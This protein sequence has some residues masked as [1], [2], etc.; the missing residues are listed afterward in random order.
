MKSWV[1]LRSCAMP[2]TKCLCCDSQ[3]ICKKKYPTQKSEKS[4]SFKIFAEN[5]AFQVNLKNFA[6][7]ISGRNCRIFKFREH[8]STLLV[9]R[10]L[11]ASQTC[12][13]G[14]PATR[15][16]RVCY[17]VIRNAVYCSVLFVPEYVYQSPKLYGW[18]LARIYHKQEATLYC[19]YSLTQNDAARKVWVQQG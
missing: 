4:R 2:G 14:Y 19:T 7:Q 13:Y 6:A 18:K 3:Q 5:P 12:K 8:H 11:Q 10:F 1:F 9:E 17:A 16:A 15:I